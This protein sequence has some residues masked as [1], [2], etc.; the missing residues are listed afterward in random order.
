MVKAIIVTHGNLAEELVNSAA[1]IIGEVSRCDAVTNANKSPQIL[2]EELEKIVD[3][4]DKDDRFILFVDFFGGSCC[5]ACLSLEQSRDNVVLISGV[6]LPMLLAFL[7]R[8][9]EVAFDELADELITRGQ[10]S[11]RTVSAERL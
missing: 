10:R 9:D 1:S 8:R 6:N 3:T 11:I 7:Y 5:H 4:G 2:I